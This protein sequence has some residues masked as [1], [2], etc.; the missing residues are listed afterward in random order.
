[1]KQQIPYFYLL[2]DWLLGATVGNHLH[3]VMDFQYL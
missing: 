2:T 1:M 3:S